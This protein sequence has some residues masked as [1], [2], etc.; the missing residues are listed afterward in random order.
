[1]KNKIVIATIFVLAAGFFLVKTDVFN[2]TNN[3]KAVQPVE[4]VAAKPIVTLILNDGENTATYS[5]V[6]AQNAF[7]ILTVVTDKEQIPLVTKKYDF[8]V[9]V[10]KIGEK[11]TNT[12]F[13]WIYFINGA[14]GEVAADKAELKNGDSVEWKYTKSIY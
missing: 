10:Q 8:G 1:M 5:G 13:G 9:F 11:E 14:S 2:T 4:I 6:S 12:V 7:E 3:Q